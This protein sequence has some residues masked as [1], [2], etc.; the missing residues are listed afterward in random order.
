MDDVGRVAGFDAGTDRLGHQ[1]DRDVLDGDPYAGMGAL[2]LPDR[3]EE[4]RSVRPVLGHQHV[5]H[6]LA[7]RSGL[8]AAGGSKKQ[9][10]QGGRGESQP[11]RASNEHLPSG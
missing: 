5:Q 8:V 6:H 9:D 7:G 10:G 3:R 4:R 2:E 11:A 1:S